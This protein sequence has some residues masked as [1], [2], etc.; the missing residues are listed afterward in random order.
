[1]SYGA[2]PAGPGWA[3]AWA[4]YR[5]PLGHPGRLLFDVTLDEPVLLPPQKRP[6][7][8]ALFASPRP[9]VLTYALEEILAEKLRSI[10]QRG[11]ARDYYDV[12]RLLG[13]K[14][15]TYD[16]PAARRLFLQKCDVKGLSEPSAAA[17][18]DRTLLD[19]A[20]PFWSRDLTGQVTGAFPVWDDVVADLERLLP[21]F[22]AT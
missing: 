19:G 8:G 7:V 18:L 9:L 10:L 2:W 11:K 17:F 16:R 14:G 20:A 4:S 1:V 21:Q 6:V 3:R 22:L 12:W 13:E 15:K 5:G